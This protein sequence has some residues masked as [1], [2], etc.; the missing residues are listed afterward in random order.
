MGSETE[1][2]ARETWFL[3]L[4]GAAWVRI[5]SWEKTLLLPIASY[6]TEREYSMDM[7]RTVLCTGRCKLPDAFIVKCG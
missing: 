7:Y 2:R 1:K 4:T 3:R 5:G 6:S